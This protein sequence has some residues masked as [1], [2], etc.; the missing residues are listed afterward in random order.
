MR[1]INPHS[2]RL[3]AAQARAA[4][5]VPAPKAKGKAEMKKPASK[6][7]AKTSKHAESKKDDSNNITP[8][9]TDYIEAKKKWMAEILDSI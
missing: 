7:K 3:L 9:R 6:K 4:K 8:S 1:P 5:G 2:Q